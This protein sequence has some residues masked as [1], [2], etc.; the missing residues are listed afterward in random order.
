MALGFEPHTERGRVL[1]CK[2]G[3]L[4]GF[5]SALEMVPEAL[6]TSLAAWHS[7]S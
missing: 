5:L 7:R 3:T 4:N 1:I 6:F 2:D